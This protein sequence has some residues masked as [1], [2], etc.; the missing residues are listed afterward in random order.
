[1][2]FAQCTTCYVVYA[3][4]LRNQVNKMADRGSSV[5]R[6]TRHRRITPLAPLLDKEFRWHKHTVGRRWRMDEAFK[7]IKE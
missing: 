3:L 7:K 6:Y 2:L 4:Y 5:D 1:M